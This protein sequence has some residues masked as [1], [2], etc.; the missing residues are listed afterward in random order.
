MEDKSTKKVLTEQEL[1]DKLTL[2]YNDIQNGVIYKEIEDKYGIK[3][4]VS[5]DLKH[6]SEEDFEYL[7]ENLAYIKERIQNGE[8]LSKVSLEFECTNLTISYIKKQLCNDFD[9]K[10]DNQPNRCIEFYK[11]AEEMWKKYNSGVS[12]EDLSCLYNIADVEETKRL[13]TRFQKL[14]NS[15]RSNNLYIPEIRRAALQEKYDFDNDTIEYIIKGK[16]KQDIISEEE[17]QQKLNSLYEDINVKKLPFENLRKA[18][19]VVPSV[20]SE[21]RCMPKEKFDEFLEKIPYIEHRINENAK[22]KTITQKIAME[23]D[24]PTRLVSY[25]AKNICKE[26]TNSK[27]QVTKDF[28]K[29]GEVTLE[30]P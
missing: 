15:E 26:Y 22:A 14:L 6:M 16:D 21:L 23:I 4:E 29:P 30:E 5:A 9:I 20:I 24:Y 1:K 3:R 17:M 19:G 27:K 8:K 10:K 12:L 7:V 11:K 25:V 13:L 18:Y 28:P 2:A